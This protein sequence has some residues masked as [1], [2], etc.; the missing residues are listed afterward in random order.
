MIH[1]LLTMLLI[2][3]YMLWNSL[4]WWHIR[5]II[6]AFMILLFMCVPPQALCSP[7]VDA[8]CGPFLAGLCL[9]SPTTCE[10][11]HFSQQAR[12]GNKSF[13]IHKHVV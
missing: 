11:G 2:I 1:L 4:A 5:F 6:I 9:A 7:S 8:R 10:P 13:A 12:I 3:A